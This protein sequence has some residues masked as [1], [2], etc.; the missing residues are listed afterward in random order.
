M[1]APPPV[2]LRFL[3][4]LAAGL[5]AR[6]DARA[7][8]GLGS[9]GRELAR[10]DRYSDLDFFVVVAPGAKEGYLAD[11]GW[12]AAPA[13]PRFVFRNT[14]DGFKVLWD[15]PA[16]EP[17]GAAAEVF[18]ECAVFEPHEL[19]D[20]P[21][22]PG[23][24]VWSR[25]GFDAAACATPQARHLPAPSDP[26]WLL[27]E[28]LTNLYVGLLRHHRGERLASLRL[29][30]TYAVGHVLALAEGLPGA[31]DAEV[32]RDPFAVERRAER[33]LPALAPLLERFCPGYGRDVEAAAALLAWLEA[34]TPVPPAMAAAVRRRL[35]G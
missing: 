32:P 25:E 15:A 24:V 27:G 28:A 3:D 30:Q 14:R 4:A 2:Q 5:A 9:V 1:T 21:F 12:L 18:G 16:G 35:A 11:T 13:P 34:H 7:L 33:R 10:V 6:P 23:R 31:V 29:V 17:A 19:A 8:L 20:I 26:A 22:A